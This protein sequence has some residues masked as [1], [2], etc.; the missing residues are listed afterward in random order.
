MERF[1]CCVWAP[2][3]CGTVAAA[4]GSGAFRLFCFVRVK[5]TN[6]K[7]GD[8]DPVGVLKCCTSLAGEAVLYTFFSS[9]FFFSCTFSD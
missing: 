1:S 7:R 4:H 5:L 8:N 2:V 6:A 3:L 9:H